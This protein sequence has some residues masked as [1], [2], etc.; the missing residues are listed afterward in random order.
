MLSVQALVRAGWRTGGSQ[1]D[2]GA[3]GATNGGTDCLSDSMVKHETG[4]ELENEQ[5]K[6]SKRDRQECKERNDD[7]NRA[8]NRGNRNGKTDM[9]LSLETGKGEPGNRKA[10][11]NAGTGTKKC[12]STLTE[13]KSNSDRVTSGAAVSQSVSF[14]NSTSSR[15]FNTSSGSSTTHYTNGTE[16]FEFF[17]LNLRSTPNYCHIITILLTV[18]AHN[19]N[20]TYIV[21]LI[22]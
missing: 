19:N 5:K 11:D 8:R 20:D 2:G 21:I 6:G 22:E 17:L 7:R 15:G 13:R 9:Y 16:R 4:K 1:Y 12:L 3:D 10:D 14:G 18:L